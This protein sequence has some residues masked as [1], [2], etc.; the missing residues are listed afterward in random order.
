LREDLEKRHNMKVYVATNKEEA[1]R[2]A[3]EHWDELDVAILDVRLDEAGTSPTGPEII[4]EV[5]EKKKE[6]FP[7]EFIV[8]TS[9][10]E[11]EYYRFALNLGAAAYLMKGSDPAI[12]HTKVLALRRALN[13]RNPKIA[14]EVER[15]AAQSRS[16]G[17]AILTFC[18]TVLAPTFE[19][20]L[21]APF[22]ILFTEGGT[23]LNCAG[24]VPKLPDGSPDFYHTLQA[25]AHGKGS[26]TDPF[27]LDISK[28]QPSPADTPLAIKF[29]HAAFLPLP[30]SGGIRLSVCIL[31]PEG[32]EGK[33]SREL[34]FAEFKYMKHVKQS[35]E[36]C[37]CTVLAQHLRPTVLENIISLWS[38]W[39]ESA[40][41]LNS[42]AKLCL[43]VGQEV[44]AGLD[45]EEPEQMLQE[46]A[47]DLIST[48]QYLDHVSRN[49]R[50][51]GEDINIRKLI[52]TSWKLIGE[53]GAR[54]VPSLDIDG[55]CVVR[56]QKRDVAIIVSRLLQWFAY[57]GGSTPSG[58]PPAVTVKCETRD[59]GAALI[60]EDHS[61]RLPPELRRRLF[62]TFSQA[63]STP[64][65]ELESAKFEFGAEGQGRK[66]EAPQLQG[67]YLPLYLVKILVEARYHGLLKDLSD[68]IAEHPYG[69]RILV[70]LPAANHVN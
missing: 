64:F 30:L 34:N 22:V 69:H 48:S 8:W 50:V 24:N 59:G 66:G 27:V 54:D 36:E 56:A 70:Q 29:E 38:Q 33:K 51:E 15:I 43:R 37:L 4:M 13:G 44:S 42:I 32:E 28:L 39:T 52:E 45:A 40:V 18:R 2:Q 25:L 9:F 11:K 61:T 60:F 63:I 14:S 31:R 20:Y 26:P 46:L 68:E 65:P 21:G 6:S 17:E 10:D 12:I 57:R 55:D 35:Y 53:P 41:K 62:E 3:E 67:R 16:I 7:P 19:T 58:I 49:W 23:T 47:D 5:R 1:R